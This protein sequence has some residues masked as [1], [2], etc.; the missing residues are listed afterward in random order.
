MFGGLIA[1]ATYSDVTLLT[2][3]E[4]HQKLDT[5]HQ[6][7]DQAGWWIPEL[8]VQTSIRIGP[9][10]S[11]ILEE[12]NAKEYDLVVIKSRQAVLIKNFL[13]SKISR[14]V[15][16]F[17]PTSVLV[18]KKKQTDLKRILT[19]TCGSVIADPVIRMSALLAKPNQAS[20]TLLHVTS[21]IPTMYTGLNKVDEQ[22]SDMLKTDTPI[23]KHLRKAARLYATEGVE[24]QLK[25]RHGAVP[26]EILV[27][28]QTGE[29]DLIIVG[30]SRASSS[31]T[32]WLLG[33]ITLKIVNQAR[34]PVMIVRKN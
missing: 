29:Y 21:S 15:A 25:L 34:C 10:A 22:F 20:V 24:A 7:L 27:E 30:G 11:G 23:A 8:D 6:V 31:L 5:A 28:A 9:D 2:V 18:I 13:A 17:S 19:C 33:D 1:R 4:D 12:I 32:G 14:K 16:R 26:D 3:I